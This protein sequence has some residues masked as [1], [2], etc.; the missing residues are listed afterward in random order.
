MSVL[1]LARVFMLSIPYPPNDEVFTPHFRSCMYWALVISINPEHV[2]F[3]LLLYENSSLRY[4][5][6]TGPR[7]Y[8][9]FFHPR[10][11]GVQE[12]SASAEGTSEETWEVLAAQMCRFDRIFAREMPKIKFVSANS[13]G[14]LQKSRRSHLT[15]RHMGFSRISALVHLPLTYHV[16]VLR[17]HLRTCASWKQ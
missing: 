12:Y 3:H 14:F 4:A 5:K 2:H 7:M 11:K 15:T 13:F 1:F 8:V 6:R 9:N 10:A 16:H 17:V